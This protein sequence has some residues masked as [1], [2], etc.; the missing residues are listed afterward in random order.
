MARRSDIRN[1]GD[2]RVPEF[3]AGIHFE[4]LPGIDPPILRQCNLN[5]NLPCDLRN[6]MP[7]GIVVEA[8]SN[9]WGPGTTDEMILESNPTAPPPPPLPPA[10]KDNCLFNVRQ[11]CDGLDYPSGGGLS[12]VRFCHWLDR[13]AP[14]FPSSG[15]AVAGNP[16][17]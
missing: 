1:N 12:G 9:Y 5:L 7:T 16:A 17:P 6:V 8:D 4:G 14:N 3:S 15:M 2:N 11:I 13:P 10:L